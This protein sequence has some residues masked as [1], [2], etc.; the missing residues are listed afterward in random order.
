M[1]L[2][3][4]C[5]STTKHSLAAIILCVSLCLRDFCSSRRLLIKVLLYRLITKDLF[6]QIS[7]LKKAVLYVVQCIFQKIKFYFQVGYLIDFVDMKHTF[8]N[9]LKRMKL[10]SSYFSKKYFLKVNSFNLFPLS[11]QK[12]PLYHHTFQIAILA[13]FPVQFNSICILC[14][15]CLHRFSNFLVAILSLLWSIP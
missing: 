10:S 2:C 15:H 3:I 1:L 14:C 11:S 12:H 4:I 9:F 5:A 6:F 7:S 8:Y 13:K